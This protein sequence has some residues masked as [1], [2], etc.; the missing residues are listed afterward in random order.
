[1]EKCVSQYLQGGEMTKRKIE[2][3]DIN[4]KIGDETLSLTLEEAKDLKNVLEEL[5]NKR[6]VID[7]LNPGLIPR[8]PM[9]PF[10]T[11]TVPVSPTN[12]YEITCGTAQI[13]TKGFNNGN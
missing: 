7:F 8:T 10:T 6:E 2:L 11:P 9:A 13:N 1:M 4:I 3:A 5:F 12:P